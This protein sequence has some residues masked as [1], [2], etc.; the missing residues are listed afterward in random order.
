M[1]YLSLNC[2]LAVTPKKTRSAAKTVEKPAGRPADRK[3]TKFF[4]HVA[5]V[6]LEVYG[7]GP[8]EVF[9]KAALEMF[10]IM[11]DTRKISRKVSRAVKAE[12]RDFEGLL[13]SFL[14]QFL[15]LH[16]AENLMFSRF[17]ANRISREGGKYTVEAEAW[18]EEF[19]E[20]RH[21]SLTLVKAITYHDMKVGRRGKVWFAHMLFDI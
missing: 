4:R 12:G 6:E 11:T 8:E 5:D 21:E 20:K 18:G 19:D 15:I 13:Y 3:K 17:K 10:R 16:D 1:F 14:E 2:D 7:S 9:E